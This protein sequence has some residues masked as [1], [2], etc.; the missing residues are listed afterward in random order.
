MAT[1]KLALT[2]WERRRILFFG[3]D[4]KRMKRKLRIKAHA[5]DAFKAVK[6]QEVTALMVQPQHRMTSITLSD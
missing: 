5:D 2:C 6:K 3:G 1:L 4:N